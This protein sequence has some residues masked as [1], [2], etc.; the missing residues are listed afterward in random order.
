MEGPH[1]REEEA[2]RSL[3]SEWMMEY[4]VWIGIF[5]TVGFAISII[6]MFAVM[7]VQ[8][9]YHSGVRDGYQNTWLPR[10]KE[11]VQEEGLSQGEEI[12]LP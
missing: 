12:M 11:Q 7:A 2:G 3:E 1:R 8:A 5:V 4:E 10:V 9:A 6:I